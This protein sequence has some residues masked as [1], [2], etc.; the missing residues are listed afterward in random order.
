MRIRRLGEPVLRGETRAVERFDDELRRLADD[1][2]E[3]MYDA[4]GVGLAAPQVG[5][6]MRLFVF[7]DGHGERGVV[8]NPELSGHEGEQL[9]EEGCLS[10]PGLF[11][12]TKRALR[13]RLRGVG[14]DGRP[15]DRVAEEHLARIFQHETDHLNK[16]LYIDHLEGEPR[17]E[18]M[19]AI[20]DLELGTAGR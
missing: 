20:R 13:V 9:Y 16:T 4:P 17:A 12:P 8:A 11:F 3:T 5:L 19:R 6:A 14:L 10:I 7:D 2:F 15:I 1:M 18:A